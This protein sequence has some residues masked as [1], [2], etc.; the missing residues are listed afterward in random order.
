M[1]TEGKYDVEFMF[2][3]VSY[4]RSSLVNGIGQLKRKHYSG[5]DRERKGDDELITLVRV[6]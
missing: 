6:E 4:N 1:F 3:N 5:I 2:I